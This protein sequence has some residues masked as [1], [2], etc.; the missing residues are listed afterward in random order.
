MKRTI[1]IITLAAALLGA[2]V[3]F[4]TKAEKAKLSIQAKAISPA[5]TPGK[6]LQNPASAPNL[7][8]SASAFITPI[9]DSDAE[10]SAAESAAWQKLNSDYTALGG[11]ANVAAASRIGEYLAQFPDSPHASSL[12]LEKSEIE[13]RHGFF[14]ASLDS[15]R[16]AWKIGNNLQSVEGK[17]I[18]ESGLIVLLNRPW[19]LGTKEEL[20][21]THGRTYYNGSMFQR[22]S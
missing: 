13:W 20:T 22:P 1:C 16:N 7:N 14:T 17:R 4:T 10:M 12:W 3:Y 19:Q 5:P 8:A 15:I 18:G 21:P 9:R 2:A 6:R 11:W